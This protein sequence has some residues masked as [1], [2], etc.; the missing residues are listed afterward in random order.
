MH[1]SRTG[2]EQRRLSV[3]LPPLLGDEVLARA[4]RRRISYSALIA[5]VLAG[6][7]GMA[8]EGES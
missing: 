5:E 2:K 7:F 3:Y 4:S 6:A 1:I 8:L